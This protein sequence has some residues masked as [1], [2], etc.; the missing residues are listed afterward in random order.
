[1]N[2]SVTFLD[3]ENKLYYV[4]YFEN[5]NLW[6][7]NNDKINATKSLINDIKRL[8]AIHPKMDLQQVKYMLFEKNT[9]SYDIRNFYTEEQIEQMKKMEKMNNETIMLSN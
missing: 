5:D 7:N 6:W 9:I 8:L 1:M 4:P 2:K 3:S